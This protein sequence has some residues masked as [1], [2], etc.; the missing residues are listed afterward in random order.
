[1]T[2]K[3]TIR[4]SRARS[5]RKGVVLLSLAIG[6]TL[7]A[8]VVLAGAAQ[9]AEATTSQKVVFVSDRTEGVDNPTGDNE[10]F[11]MNTDGTGVKQL[12]FNSVDDA[13]PALSPDG[14]K[15]AYMSRGDQ[16]SNPENDGEIYMMKASD[17][18]GKKNLTNNGDGVDD[19]SPI[20]S[21][22]SK[23]VAY[24]S[25][26]VQ[27][28]NPEGEYDVYRVNASDGTVN[29]NLT[30]NGADVRDFFPD[31][32]PDGTRIAYTSEGTQTSNPEG[33]REIYLMKTLDGTGKKNLSN[34]K[35]AYDH[36][37]D[38]SPGGKTIAYE[39]DGKQA[40][41]LEGDDEVY[42]MNAAD[43]TGKKNLTNNG[44]GVNDNNPVF[45][46]DGKT[47]AYRSNGI[48]PSN[49][50]GDYEI[51][52]L[53]ASDGTGKR[54]L[55]SN[56]DGVSDAYP[57]FSPDGTRIVYESYGAQTSNPE[58]DEEVYR[59]KALDGTGKKNLTNNQ[60]DDYSP[61]WGVQRT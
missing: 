3:A 61:D 59:M 26:G 48:Q 22:D 56:G 45:S 53:D 18:S 55:S 51:Y 44:S 21:P 28:S 4:G 49:P 32:S 16:T 1:M 60:A 52:R 41:N 58:G 19:Y 36:S 38:F 7:S 47:M 54:N 31:F 23:K 50:Q 17:G 6:A 11:T 2:S 27:P 25:Q 46:P 30:N 13:E 8:A 29:K 33:D 34:N 39:S 12:T 57:I 5:N 15:I 24:S 10:I 9:R 20:F 37:P 43:G 40:S 42:R 35:A 14:T